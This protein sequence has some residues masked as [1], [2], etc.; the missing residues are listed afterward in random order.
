MY[1]GF[2]NTRD[3]VSKYLDL[4]SLKMDGGHS[5]WLLELELDILTYHLEKKFGILQLSE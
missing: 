3:Q 1:T 2:T 5:H 4:P